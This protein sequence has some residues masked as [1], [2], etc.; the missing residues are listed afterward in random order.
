[1]FE[2]DLSLLAAKPKFAKSQKSKSNEKY[3][4]EF[5]RDRDRILYSKEFRRLNGKT[6]VFISSFGDYTRNRLTHSLEVAQIAKTIAKALNLNEDLTEA[7]A[8]GH[9]VG[10]APFGHAGERTLNYIMNGCLDCYGYNSMLGIEE[11]GFKHNLQSIRV[12]C[13]LE[14]GYEKEKGNGLK[15]C[16]Y[17]LW[18]MMNHSTLEYEKECE[19]YRCSE[20]HY[21]NS[22]K[23]CNK[24]IVGFYNKYRRMLNDETDWSLEGVIV[25]VA[26]EIAQRHHDIEDGIFAGL[27]DAS[28]LCIKLR[29]E[30]LISEDK[31]RELIN[32]CKNNLQTEVIQ[33]I[34][35]VIVDSYVKKYL[36][37]IWKQTKLF[38]ESYT[39]KKEDDY[40]KIRKD[41][42]HQI[43]SKYNKPI[44]KCLGISGELKEKD[45]EISEY[46]QYRV[47]K[48]DVTQNMDGKARFVIIKLL[49]A[50]L[51]NPQQLP[52][53]TII[54]IVKEMRPKFNTKDKYIIQ[55]GKARSELGDLMK[56]SDSKFD[57]ILLR[58]IVD[59]IAGMT[60]DYALSQYKKLYGSYVPKSE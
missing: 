8:L 29:K 49:K 18:G 5:V 2:H 15:L 9:D 46:I 40:N 43:I 19:Y 20:C 50:Y 41:F 7:I 16:N 55:K 42:Y 59:F 23:Q 54:S 58:K 57:H 28:D 60:D 30:K 38:V 36:N 22:K 3:R 52:D 32:I 24:L 26:D 47:H 17:T 25:S 11:R 34:S 10:H 39:S 37:F 33:S 35:E 53:K 31:K 4:D 44:I 45:L 1:M 6:Q 14:E 51:T 56:D 12:V 27:I 13:D 48:S 21:K